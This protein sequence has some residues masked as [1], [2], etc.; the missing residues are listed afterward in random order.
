MPKAEVSLREVTADTMRAICDLD[1]GDGGR[2]VARK[3]GLDCG[4]VL[5]AE[6]LVPRRLLKGVSG[7]MRL[8]AAHRPA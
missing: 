4:G 8:H 1:A 5:Q 7:V 3:R 6:G 2:S